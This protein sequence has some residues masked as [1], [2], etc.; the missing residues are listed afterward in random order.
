MGC[1]PRR[2]TC[3]R[4]GCGVEAAGWQAAVGFANVWANRV[5]EKGNVVWYGGLG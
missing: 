1:C 5:V 4:R 3:W 2:P